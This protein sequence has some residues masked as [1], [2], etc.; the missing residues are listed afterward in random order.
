MGEGRGPSPTH[1]APAACSCS[2]A[3][4]SCVCPPLQAVVVVT[5]AAEPHIVPYRLW[6]AR[7]SYPVSQNCGASM[8][9]QEQQGW[10]S[11]KGRSSRVGS[12]AGQRAAACLR[13]GLHY[14]DAWQAGGQAGI[15][16][17]TLPQTQQLPPAYLLAHTPASR[18]Q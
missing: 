12:T 4:P 1:P 10:T 5:A 7:I 15:A 17:A 14:P 11:S 8:S 2:A 3:W 9:G 13:H 16:P 18:P 6:D